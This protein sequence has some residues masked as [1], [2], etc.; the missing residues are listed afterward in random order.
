[1]QKEPPPTGSGSCVLGR[2]VLAGDLAG[3]EAA[4]A[5]VQ[6]LGRAVDRRAHALDVGVEATLRNLARP[7]AVVTE[8]RALGADVTD[9]S[10]RELLGL[11]GCTDS[12]VALGG[13]RATAQEY[14]TT[15]SGRESSGAEASTHR[16]DRA[17]DRSWARAAEPSQP[18]TTL[19]VP[20]RRADPH[21]ERRRRG[22]MPGE[23]V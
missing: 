14:P 12:G 18:C 3:L 19:T 17:F 8:A 6:A 21:A 5:D 11:L 22:P 2:E 1:M 23:G 10:H 13:V 15:S 7:G 16:P 4:G 20:E 9:G